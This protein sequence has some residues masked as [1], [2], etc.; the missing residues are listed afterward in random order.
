MGIVTQLA[1][2]GIRGEK[3]RVRQHGGSSRARGDRQREEGARDRGNAIRGSLRGDQ[4]R[5]RRQGHHLQPH[6]RLSCYQ[7]LGLVIEHGTY[8]EGQVLRDSSMS[9][10]LASKTLELNPNNAIIRGLE[11]SPR[12]KPTNLFATSHVLFKTGLWIRAA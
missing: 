7:G 3:A 9:S 10:Y 11:K 5:T 12:T 8:H 4:G 6:H 2:Q 1:A